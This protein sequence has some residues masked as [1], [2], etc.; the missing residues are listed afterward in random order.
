MGDGSSGADRFA[1]AR[2][3]SIEDSSGRTMAFRQLSNGRLFNERTLSQ[4]NAS[5]SLSQLAQRA[6]Q[7]GSTVRVHTQEEFT[8]LFTP[9]QELTAADEYDAIRNTRS[10]ERVYRPRRR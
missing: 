9:K 3:I 10:R 8:R 4:V 6:E 1:N 2:Y 7:S 5:L